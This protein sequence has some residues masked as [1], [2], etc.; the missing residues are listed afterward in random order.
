M[1]T[2]LDLQTNFSHV[3]TIG[4]HVS[5]ENESQVVRQDV[6][7]GHI[8]KESEK[9]AE[10]VPQ[11]LKN[12]KDYAKIKDDPNHRRHNSGAGS[13]DDD[14]H[15]EEQNRSSSAQKKK[16]VHRIENPNEGINIDIMC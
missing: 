16:T 11:V 8:Q 15:S 3:G 6:I 7:S 14:D 13:D 1:V 12:D 5:A 9:N 4:R 2:P 10:D